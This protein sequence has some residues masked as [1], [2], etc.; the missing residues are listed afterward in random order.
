[1]I[2]I[3]KILK[4]GIPFLA[5]W[6]GYSLG[7]TYEENKWLAKKT[8]YLEQI[9]SLKAT[10]IAKERQYREEIDR[11]SL[12]FDNQRKQ[13]EKSLADIRSSYDDRLSESSMRE[14]LYRKQSRGS[15]LERQRLAE[16]AT[17][18]D[19]SLSEGRLLVKEFREHL[20]LCRRHNEALIDR[21]KAEQKLWQ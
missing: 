16:Q 13:Y 4:V 10:N 11:I 1:M 17:R 5:I 14:Q 20:E 8:L 7:S 21:I 6:V 18:L 3:Q 2:T 15:E 19:R 9:N 12:N